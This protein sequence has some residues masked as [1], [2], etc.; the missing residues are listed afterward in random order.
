M[1]KRVFWIIIA[2]FVYFYVLTSGKEDEVINTFKY[3]YSYCYKKVKQMDLKVEV[4]KWPSS[5]QQQQ[6]DK[7]ENRPRRRKY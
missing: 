7:R 4:N 5:E 2:V 6:Q 1:I 3:I